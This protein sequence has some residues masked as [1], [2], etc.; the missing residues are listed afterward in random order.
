MIIG[1]VPPIKYFNKEL[2][3]ELRK[4]SVSVGAA[5]SKYE[6]GMILNL[7]KS[8]E[9]DPDVWVGCRFAFPHVDDWNSGRL[10]LTLSVSGK[11]FAFGDANISKKIKDSEWI[12]SGTLFL[13]NPNVIHWLHRPDDWA[14]NKFWAGVQWEIPVKNWKKRVRE[15]TENLINFEPRNIPIL[16]KQT[17]SRK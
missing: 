7:V 13:V 4:T 12:P 1:N 10:F 5:T 6:T 17:S 8:P 14:T 15:I 11:D 9:Y 16:K 2:F 3:S